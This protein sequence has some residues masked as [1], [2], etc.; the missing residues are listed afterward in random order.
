[1]LKKE[2]LKN[3]NLSSGIFVKKWI[4]DTFNDVDLS[5][6]L[7]S[8]RKYY[9]NILLYHIFVIDFFIRLLCNASV[10]FYT[11]KFCLKFRI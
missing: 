3:S 11:T 2:G 9:R 5:F 7:F 10:L 4:K 1:M 8:T 6:F